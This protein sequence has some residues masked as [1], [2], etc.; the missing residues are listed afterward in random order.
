[1]LELSIFALFEF[2]RYLREGEYVRCGEFHHF[3][4]PVG[5]LKSPCNLTFVFL[6]I[7]DFIIKVS[8]IPCTV[9]NILSHTTT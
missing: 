2:N 1:M 6:F 7:L 3:W 5:A 9:M 4:A 8:Y